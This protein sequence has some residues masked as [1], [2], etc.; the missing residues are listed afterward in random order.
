MD[1]MYA[2]V[3]VK[4]GSHRAFMNAKYI[5]LTV[6]FTDFQPNVTTESFYILKLETAYK[7]KTDLFV[8]Y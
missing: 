8:K 5:L 2:R 3:T 7:L 1:S 6:I 4:F